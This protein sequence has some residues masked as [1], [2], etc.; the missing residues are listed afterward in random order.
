MA[1]K[2]T[3]YKATVSLSDMDRHVYDELQL[4]L[5]QHPSET[6]ERMM[7]RL[8]AFCLNAD[9][10]L[11]FSRGLSNPDEPAL[12]QVDHSQQIEHW[13]EVGQPE[14][15]RVKKG[16]NQSR[17]VSVYAFGK[18]ADVWWELQRGAFEKLS[19]VSVYQF[20]W[21]QVQ[22]LAQFVARTMSLTVTITDGVIYINGDQG[23]LEIVPQ[24]L[25]VETD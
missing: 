11:A 18:S 24:P 25:L 5:A 10:Q 6:V 13:I 12:W 9:P 3:I 14:A 19:K 8:L 22:Q 17:R 20:S 21:S 15:D 23:A 1:L 4:T 7:V 16:A 2:P